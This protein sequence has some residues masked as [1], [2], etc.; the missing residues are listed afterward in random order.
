MG[1][2]GRIKNRL[3]IREFALAE[4]VS[5]VGTTNALPVGLRIPAFR[6]LARSPLSFVALR[7]TSRARAPRFPRLSRLDGPAA[8]GLQRI[9]KARRYTELE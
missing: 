7:R 8:P 9:A 4:A 6:R 5:S 3:T 1:Q 2:M